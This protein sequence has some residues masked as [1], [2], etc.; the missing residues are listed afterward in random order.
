MFDISKNTP[1]MTPDCPFCNPTSDALF[2]QGALAIGM[3]APEPAAPGHA[4]VTTRRHVGDWFA[5]SPAEQ[6]E[7]LRINATSTYRTES[8]MLRNYGTRLYLWT[9]KWSARPVSFQ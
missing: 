3:W 8:T 6:R 7:I 1:P 2:H 4:L 5:A 9:H